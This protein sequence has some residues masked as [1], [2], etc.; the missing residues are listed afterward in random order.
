[1]H[2]CNGC[3]HTISTMSYALY[4]IYGL[5]RKS[6]C[7]IHILQK[8]VHALYICMINMCMTP[9]HNLKSAT[10]SHLYS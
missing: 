2:I 9:Y 1:M 7:Y 4:Y 5:D 3:Q 10:S 8:C 6:G